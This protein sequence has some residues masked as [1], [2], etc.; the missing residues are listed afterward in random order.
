MIS[1]FVPGEPYSKAR[2]KFAKHAYTPK[3]TKAKEQ[4]IQDEF[5]D[6]YPNHI[7]YD[8]EVTVTI[9]LFCGTKVKRDIDNQQ[10]L[11]LDALNKLAFK[12]DSQINELHAVRR[13]ALGDEVAGTWIEITGTYL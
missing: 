5:R 4:L 2:P 10:K 12:D 13:G 11:V 1:F 9:K 8:G 7:P 3:A 6:C